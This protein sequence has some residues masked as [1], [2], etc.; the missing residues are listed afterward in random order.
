MDTQN[1][2]EEWVTEILRAALAGVAPNIATMSLAEY[3]TTT[4]DLSLRGLELKTLDPYLAGWRRRVVPALGHFPVRTITNAGD[5]LTAHLTPIRAP[6]TRRA[7][8]PRTPP[9]DRV[10]PNWSPEQRK[11]RYRI[12]PTP[13][14]TCE[15]TSRDDRI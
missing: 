12:S 2:A 8:C 5:A 13:P 10:V 6:I 14:A 1:Q 11:R 7:T 9:L 3:G 4:M 15:N